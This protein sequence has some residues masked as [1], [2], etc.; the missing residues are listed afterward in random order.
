MV[1]VRSQT[2]IIVGLVL[3]SFNG[4]SSDTKPGEKYQNNTVENGS[5]F[6]ELNTG[7]VYFWD[8]SGKAWL[9]V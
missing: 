2:R 9:E 1:T 3:Y 6:F 5:S 8:R 7:K 4:L